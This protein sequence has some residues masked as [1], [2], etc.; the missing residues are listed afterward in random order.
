MGNKIFINDSQKLDAWLKMRL[1]SCRLQ[2][3]ISNNNA[4]TTRYLILLTKIILMACCLHN[5][6][7]HDPDFDPNNQ[8]DDVRL[9]F[10]NIPATN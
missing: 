6:L 1:V 9:I 4:N 8:F 7:C 5:L 3:N 2:E 10:L